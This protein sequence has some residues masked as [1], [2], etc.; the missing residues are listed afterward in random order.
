M[1][2]DAPLENQALMALI[3]VSKTVTSSLDLHEVLARVIRAADATVGVEA[4]SL[5][6]VD[7]ETGNLFFEVAQGDKSDAVRRVLVP[8]GDGVAGWSARNREAVVVNDVDGDPRFAAWV[9]TVTGFQ[10]RSLLCV[11][12]VYRDKLLG[13]MEL[14]NKVDASGFG[15]REVA[16]CESI[17]SLAAIAIDNAQV[18]AEQLKAARLAAVG[19][20]VARLAHGIKNILNGIRGGSYIL[21]RAVRCSNEAG[22]TKGN[23][24][25]KRNSEVLAGL[26][27]DM[28]AYSSERRPQ[29]SRTDLGELCTAV[30]E[31]MCEVARERNVTVHCDAPA[32]PEL[33]IDPVGIRRAVLNLVSN[34]IDACPEDGAG[35]V[36][37]RTELHADDDVCIRVADNGCGISA[38]DMPKLFREFFSTKGFRGTG[39][40]LP[41]SHQ[42]VCQH[43]GRIEVQSEA[44]EGTEFI[45]HLPATP[46]DAD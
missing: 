35:V 33:M 22:I 20:T 45:L 23:G 10:T 39:L 4:A 16:L 7:E 38:E 29:R 36:S 8:L 41:V 21:D 14:V 13:V 27:L 43:G 9:D 18:H 44:G 30:A 40:G 34:A 32:G 24:M 5:L 19:Q 12:V 42:I 1:E 26:V 37:L 31:S 11:P 17:A 2:T 28:L 25:V 6:L 15:Q 46:P 3:E